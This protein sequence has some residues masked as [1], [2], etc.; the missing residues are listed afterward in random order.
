MLVLC[1]REKFW[2]RIK[3]NNVFFQLDDN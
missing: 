2:T 3:I 1:E